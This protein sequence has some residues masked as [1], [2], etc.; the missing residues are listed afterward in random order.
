[1]SHLA[2]AL[3]PWKIV[4]APQNYTVLE[5]LS[6]LELSGIKFEVL[7]LAS[8]LSPTSTIETLY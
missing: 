6:S 3:L 8:W 7:D 1:M 2:M 4:F 5:K